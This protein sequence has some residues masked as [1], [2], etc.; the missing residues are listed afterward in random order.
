MYF[1]ITDV[2]VCPGALHREMQLVPVC[3]NVSLKPLE[4]L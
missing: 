2:E 3:H 4:I 1:G